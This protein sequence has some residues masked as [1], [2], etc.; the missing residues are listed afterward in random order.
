VRKERAKWVMN[1]FKDISPKNALLIAVL[2]SNVRIRSNTTI[3]IALE[4]RY[5]ASNAMKS[6]LRL[7]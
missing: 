5:F 4:L 6:F 7:T 3:M 1:N 2:L